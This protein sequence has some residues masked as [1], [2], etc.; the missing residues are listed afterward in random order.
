MCLLNS[1]RGKLSERSYDNYALQG[2]KIQI[3]QIFTVYQCGEQGVRVQDLSGISCAGS[4]L[5]L[6]QCINLMI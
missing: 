4:S 5:E 1:G 2:D 3:P 6:L